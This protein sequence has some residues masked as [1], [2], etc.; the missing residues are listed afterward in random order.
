MS[1]LRCLLQ[2]SR[3][4]QHPSTYNKWNSLPFDASFNYYGQCLWCYHRVNVVRGLMQILTWCTSLC[5]CYQVVNDLLFWMWNSLRRLRPFIFYYRRLIH[6]MTQVFASFLRT[7]TAQASVFITWPLNNTSP[8]F[9]LPE[10]PTTLC[11]HESRSGAC[12]HTFL[13]SSDTCTSS[14]NWDILNQSE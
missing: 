5:L 8:E 4:T 10:W 1:S 2:H 11:R 3:D 14:N 9:L 6:Y 13:T 12:L 7:P